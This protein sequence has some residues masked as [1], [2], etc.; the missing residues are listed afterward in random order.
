MKRFRPVSEDCC[1]KFRQRRLVRKRLR[2]RRMKDLIRGLV[3]KRTPEGICV[4]SAHY[5]ADPDRADQ[6][7]SNLSKIHLG[8]CLAAGT[9]NA[10]LCR[11]R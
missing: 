10:I 2:E 9:R 11:R 3:E 8:K 6:S 7:G 5:T 1:S 4:L